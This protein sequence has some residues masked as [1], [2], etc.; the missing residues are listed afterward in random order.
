VSEAG[1]QPRGAGV[2][3]DALVAEF[4]SAVRGG[5]WDRYLERFT[6][7]AVLEFVGPPAGPFGG[8]EAI[9]AAYRDAPPDDTIAVVAPPST[10]GD[11]TVVAYRW[12]DSGATGSMRI[13][14]RAGR[15]S[16][17]VVTFD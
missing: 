16:R 2:D 15:I 14:A 7:D 17:L 6:D 1:T 5:R 10:A 8:R 4:N 12:N 13:T 9:A 11:E 3:V